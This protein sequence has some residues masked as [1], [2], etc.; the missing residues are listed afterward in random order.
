[1]AS[2]IKTVAAASKTSPIA[3][4]TLLGERSSNLAKATWTGAVLTSDEPP[5]LCLG[6]ADHPPNDASAHDEDFWSRHIQGVN[7]VFGDGSVHAISNTVEEA[8]YQA[9]ATRNNGEVV[10]YSP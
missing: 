8:I 4:A 3:R 5:A 7:F 10:S 9:L 1:M 2:F 6:S